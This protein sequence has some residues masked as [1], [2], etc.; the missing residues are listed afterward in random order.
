MGSCQI[1]WTTAYES[2]ITTWTGSCL[3]EK[4]SFTLHQ[5][6]SEHFYME[7]RL[8]IEW[9]FLGLGDDEQDAQDSWLRFDRE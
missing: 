3:I 8:S 6:N 2:S 7:G 4:E 1:S 9:Q 5:I